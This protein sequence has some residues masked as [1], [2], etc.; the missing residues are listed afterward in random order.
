MLGRQ[1]WSECLARSL[2]MLPHQSL[3]APSQ[4]GILGVV[5]RFSRIP[6]HQ[7][8]CAA[9][10]ILTP[11]PFG[12]SVAQSQYGCCFHLGHPSGFHSRQ[13]DTPAPFPFPHP[14]PFQPDLLGPVSWGH[15]YRSKKGT[16]SSRF[17]RW[18]SYSRPW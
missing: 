3:R 14:C 4:L 8:R 11:Q 13:E 10:L 16:F 1:R 17:N 12:L 18:Y 15:F 9:L 5:G 2:I 6:M 7:G